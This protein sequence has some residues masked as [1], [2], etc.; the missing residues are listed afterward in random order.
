MPVDGDFVLRV[1]IFQE[2][3]TAKLYYKGSDNIE[4]LLDEFEQEFETDELEFIIIERDYIAVLYSIAEF[5]FILGTAPFILH[6]ENSPLSHLL[7][8][9]AA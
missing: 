3:F 9:H 4:S 2:S 8:I 1:H 5:A 6:T 7:G